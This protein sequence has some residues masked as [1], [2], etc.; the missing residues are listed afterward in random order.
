MASPLFG[1]DDDKAPAAPAQAA[2]PPAAPAAADSLVGFAANTVEFRSLWRRALAYKD[3]S[4]ESDS[5]WT[6][7]FF[8]RVDW[9]WWRVWTLM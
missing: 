5:E 8:F 3:C 4:I 1:N 7:S 2:A 6:L 9:H